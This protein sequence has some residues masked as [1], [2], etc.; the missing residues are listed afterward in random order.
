MG[1]ETTSNRFIR[2]LLMEESGHATCQPRRADDKGERILL[3]ERLY[4]R[5]EVKE[6]NRRRAGLLAVSCRPGPRA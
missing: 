5:L 3:L 4:I 1:V 2:T 6:E